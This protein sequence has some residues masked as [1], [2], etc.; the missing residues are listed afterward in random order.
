MQHC[1]MHAPDFHIQNFSSG[2]K[3]IY[4]SK[5]D[6]SESNIST[7]EFRGLDLHFKA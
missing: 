5:G 2:S 1:E 7:F 6:L 3:I 4:I